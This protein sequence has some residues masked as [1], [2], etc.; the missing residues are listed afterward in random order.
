MGPSGI[1]EWEAPLC[2]AFRVSCHQVSH[3]CVLYVVWVSGGNRKGPQFACSLGHKSGQIGPRAADATEFSSRNDAKVQTVFA[4]GRAC[5]CE[6]DK[7]VAFKLRPC[8]YVDSHPT[9]HSIRQYSCRVQECTQ[10][11]TS[12]NG[13]EAVCYSSSDN[14]LVPDKPSGQASCAQATRTVCPSHSLFWPRQPMT[15]RHASA[16][17]EWWSAP[18][19]ALCN[20]TAIRACVSLL[21]CLVT[22]HPSSLVSRL[23]WACRPFDTP[24]SRH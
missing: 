11:H 1:W 2:T 13:W 24:L 22:L 4:L 23:F 12:L 5:S 6:Q 16:W 14:G 3:H 17:R 18:L 19:S 7:D 21:R 10:G 9:G 8:F 20:Q 15:L